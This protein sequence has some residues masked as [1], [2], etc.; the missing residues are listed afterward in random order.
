MLLGA[1][2]VLKL[3]F[4]CALVFLNCSFVVREQVHLNIN[5]LLTPPPGSTQGV[6]GYPQEIHRK[7]TGYTQ[8]VHKLCIKLSTGSAQVTHRLYPCTTLV[9]LGGLKWCKV[10]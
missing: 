6:P 9:H 2:V 7:H 8:A 4:C 10:G 3:L 5:R 1:F